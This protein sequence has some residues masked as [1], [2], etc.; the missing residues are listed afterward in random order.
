MDVTLLKNLLSRFSKYAFQS[1]VFKLMTSQYGKEAIKLKPKLGEGIFSRDVTDEIF[2]AELGSKGVGES[3]RGTYHSLYI[4]HFLPLELMKSPDQIDIA[5]PLILNTLESIHSFYKRKKIILPMPGLESPLQGL[6]FINNISGFSMQ[7]HTESLLP[8][9]RELAS[10][11]RFWFP[12]VGVGNIDSFFEREPMKTENVLK[13]F[14]QSNQE[15]ICISLSKDEV[16][17]NKYSSEKP[18]FSGVGRRSLDPYEPLFTYSPPEEKLLLD[19]FEALISSDAKES[20]LEEFLAEH[21]KDIFGIKYDRIETQLWLKFPGLDISGKDRRLDLFLRNSV[22]SDWELFEVKRAIDLTGTYRDIP[23]VKQ[24][25][26]YAMQQVKN[27]ARILA[28]DSVRRKFADEGIEYY[29]PAL[30]LIVGRKP[31]LPLKQWRHLVA[32]NENGVKLITFDDLLKEL[33]LRL[34]DRQSTL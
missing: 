1:F 31:Q 20:L 9:Y 33:E 13:S 26:L 16:E 15:G 8:K 27:Y 3:W 10:F 7:E 30:H 6:F 5:D 2:A 4:T 25:V 14:L 34:R 11:F 24:E 19:E 21:Y 12:E 18:M 29:E 23:V 17:V 32:N 28:Q 22:T